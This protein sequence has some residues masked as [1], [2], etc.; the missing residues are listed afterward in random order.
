MES[1][2]GEEVPRV[3]CPKDAEPEDGEQFVCDATT[4]DGAHYQ[5]EYRVSNALTGEVVAVAAGI[6]HEH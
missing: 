6:S 5:V 1:K 4:L 2:S 3:V